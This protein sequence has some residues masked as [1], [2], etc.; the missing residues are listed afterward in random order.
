MSNNQNPPYYIYKIVKGNCYSCDDLIKGDK[1][2]GQKPMSEEDVIAAHND[3][4]GWNHCGELCC[5]IC[6]VC[7]D[8]HQENGDEEYVEINPVIKVT[9]I[10]F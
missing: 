9:T 5:G 2:W 1:K 7:G 8:Y 6:D 3:C 4:H 10:W